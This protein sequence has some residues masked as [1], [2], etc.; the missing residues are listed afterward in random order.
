MHIPSYS[1]QPPL[2]VG[3][4]PITSH[5]LG[6]T[7]LHDF[8]SH[9]SLGKC[10]THM[11]FNHWHQLSSKYPLEFVVPKPLKTC[12]LNNFRSRTL[13]RVGDGAVLGNSTEYRWVVS[14]LPETEP[15]SPVIC[16]TA[17]GSHIDVNFEIWHWSV[18]NQLWLKIATAISLFLRHLLVP[19]MMAPSRIRWR[20][21]GLCQN[22]FKLSRT[23]V[24]SA[25]VQPSKSPNAQILKLRIDDIERT[26]IWYETP[27]ISEAQNKLYQSLTLQ[28][29]TS[30]ARSSGALVRV[31]PGG[32]P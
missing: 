30:Q 2:W 21:D 25:L 8:W 6:I 27:S 26:E 4:S 15:D 29:T 22:I 28:L 9:P 31:H 20:I 16:N 12:N 18:F 10:G 7:P 24:I 11:S 1:L 19:E 23:G 32:L 5:Q 17:I 3:Q 13:L 14:D